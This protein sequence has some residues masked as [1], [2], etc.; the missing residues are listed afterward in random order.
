MIEICDSTPELQ[1]PEVADTVIPLSSLS[2]GELITKGRL[3]HIALREILVEQ[4]QWGKTFDNMLRSSLVNK[5]SLV[6]LF[7]S[8]KCVPPTAMPQVIG[9]VIYMTDQRE[10]S[11]R[12][13]ALK[14]TAETVSEDE[15]AV[16]GMAIKVAGADDSDEFWDLNLTGESQHK[17]VPEERFTF[18]TQWRTADPT[19]KWYGNFLR[20][21]DAF[22]H[23]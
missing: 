1:L 3:H 16:I 13:S 21:H 11:S 9:Q 2:G 8:E 10:A 7:G 17:E 4:S 23:K 15:I 19:R 5:Q 20:D 6:V 18:D 22:D 14:T 12:L